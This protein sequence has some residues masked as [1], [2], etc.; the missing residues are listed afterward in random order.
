[1]TLTEDEYRVLV[2][3]A[4]QVYEMTKH[5]GWSLLVD[6]LHMKMKGDKLKVLNNDC[7]DL[8]EYRKIAGKLVGIHFVIDAV[9]AMQKLAENERTRRAEREAV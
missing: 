2:E 7:Q 3:Q 1:M 6:Y 9:D 4:H 5:P 8:D